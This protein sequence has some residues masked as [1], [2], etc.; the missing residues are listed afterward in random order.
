MKK[1]TIF[2]LNTLMIL[3]LLTG[4]SDDNIKD[5]V[6]ISNNVTNET[7][8]IKEKGEIYT[9]GLFSYNG[10]AS[11]ENSL[12]DNDMTWVNESRLYYKFI[13]DMDNYNKYKERIDIPDLTEDDFNDKA[14]LIVSNE[15]IRDRNE[16]D[17]EISD[18]IVVEDTT[19]VKIKQK[20]NPN[21]NSE[22][23]VFYA[24]VNN[25]LLRDDVNVVIEHDN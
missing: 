11:Y 12:L 4:C 7:S 5:D 19:I 18:V 3:F 16:I 20:E 8:S 25:S 23:N 24:V 14:L 1:I 15:N 6:H 2:L 9:R 13:V 21:Y 22:T 17:L 10:S